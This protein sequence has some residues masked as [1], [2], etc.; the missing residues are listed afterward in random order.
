MALKFC[1]PHCHLE[2]AMMVVLP[3]PKSVEKPEQQESP[4][5]SEQPSEQ[6]P[7][8]VPGDGPAESGNDTSISNNKSMSKSSSWDRPLGSGTCSAMLG[9]DSQ[10]PLEATSVS[11]C[12]ALTRTSSSGCLESKPE[13]PGKIVAMRTTSGGTVTMTLYN[14]EGEDHF[15]DTL[16]DDG[17]SLRIVQEWFDDGIVEESIAIGTQMDPSV[18]GSE[19]DD[20][21]TGLGHDGEIESTHQ[22]A[23]SDDADN[24]HDDS[25]CTSQSAVQHDQYELGS[26]WDVP[27]FDLGGMWDV[28]KP[29][30]L[31]L[32][33]PIPSQSASMPA[34]AA[35]ARPDRDRCRSREPVALS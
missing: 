6:P 32:P 13:L 2:I 23:H 10:H 21:R 5:G 11:S 9:P 14:H 35:E 27:L 7:L 1:C 22:E 28:A 26:W 20:C 29:Q 18:D 31:S 33:R 24:S 4:S 12:P 30:P 15:G 19:V 8:L 16:I 34:E 25:K 3:E 17:A